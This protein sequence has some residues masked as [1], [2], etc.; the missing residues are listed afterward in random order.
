MCCSDIPKGARDWAVSKVGCKY[1]QAGRTQE[2]IFDCSSLVA[3]AY[4]AMGKAWKYGGRVPLSCNEVYDD[5]F[6]LLWPASYAEIG[7]HTASLRD[8]KANRPG[9]LQFLNTMKTSLRTRSPTC[10]GGVGI[11]DRPCARIGLWSADGTALTHYPGRCSAQT[12]YH[13]RVIG[14]GQRWLPHGCAAEGVKP[15]WRR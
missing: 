1:S 7:K 4:S 11:E 3:R 10:D 6:E 5:D 2:N 8:A 13:P 12:A 14:R 15:A 9:D